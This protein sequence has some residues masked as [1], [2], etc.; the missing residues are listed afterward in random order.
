[1]PAPVTRDVLRAVRSR[2]YAGR[3]TNTEIAL[4]LG[5]A[6]EQVR[7]IAAD[8]DYRPLVPPPAPPG[9]R[10]EQNTTTTPEPLTKEA[11]QARARWRA[12]EA[13]EQQQATARRRRL[14]AQG[15]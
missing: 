12:R 11:L 5:L 9:P 2:L 1:M 15:A 8:P 4:E 13:A 10:P 3:A 7:A 6:I 14:A